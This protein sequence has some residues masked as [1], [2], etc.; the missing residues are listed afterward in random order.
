[1]DEAVPNV[2][3]EDS[4]RKRLSGIDAAKAKVA[5][6]STALDKAHARVA[7]LSTDPGLQ[8][9]SKKQN[10]LAEAEKKVAKHKDELR[11]AVEK[12]EHL[13]ENG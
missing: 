10:Q 11:D 6:A 3:P 8:T 4:K 12:V 7:Q 1:M 2:A 5:K 9:Q 13:V